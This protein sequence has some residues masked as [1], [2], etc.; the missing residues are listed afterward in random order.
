LAPKKCTEWWHRDSKKLDAPCMTLEGHKLFVCDEFP[1]SE[2]GTCKSPETLGGTGVRIT[3]LLDDADG[4]VKRAVA[5]GARVS[6]P[7]R[8][9]F[10][11]GRYGKIVDPFGRQW[12]INQKVKKQSPEGTQIAADEFFAQR[13]Q[14][15]VVVD[16]EWSPR[17][18]R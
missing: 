3:L 5:A 13:K 16:C 10:W 2:G 9:M 12:G 7:V 17:P 4:V 15:K 1:A 6:M 11:G 14:P 8:D 18:G